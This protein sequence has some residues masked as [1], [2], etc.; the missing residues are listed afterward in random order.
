MGPGGS[1]S[2]LPLQGL[3]PMTNFKNHLP[4]L[5]G[6]GVLLL[7]QCQT[8]D[9][10]LANPGQPSYKPAAYHSA[11][12]TEYEAQKEVEAVRPDQDRIARHFDL[13]P[14]IDRPEVQKWIRHITG[15][16]KSSFE[17]HLQRGETL[18]PIIESVLLDKDLPTDLYYLALIE[19]GFRPEAR[20]HKKAVGVWQFI[21]G[22]GKRYGL[23]S[24]YYVD[25]RRD[26][27]RATL[28]AAGYLSDL[29][30]VFQSWFLAFS[31]YSTGEGRVLNAIMRHETRSYWKLIE[32][33]ALPAETRDYVPKLI[34][35]AW[36]AQHADRYGI[37]R[38][39]S[40]HW[41]ELHGVT[42]PAG[43]ALNKISE[44][45]GISNSD[46]GRYNPHLLR[47]VVPP[48]T[49]SYSLWLPRARISRKT[50]L[51]L[52]KIK[53]V[54]GSLK[55]AYQG[56]ENAY[57]IQAGDALHLIAKKFKVSVADIKRENQLSSNK[58]IAGRL[59]KIPGHQAL[60]PVKKKAVGKKRNIR[61]RA[62]RLL[63]Y[64]TYKVR[65]GDTLIK[66]AHKFGLSVNDLKRKNRL[67]SVA[68]FP[69]QILKLRV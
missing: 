40:L 47:G 49:S 25:E 59:L 57:R 23:R 31:A 66:I 26:P 22:T 55:K 58:L 65:R 61:K 69:G 15:P 28:A 56:P 50:E 46:I 5:F 37:R 6:S 43:V 14:W 34:A 67:T 18:R 7:T 32:K 33:K 13:E 41:P 62:S 36:V 4:K 8:T 44:I 20:S 27:V 12:Y 45:A 10:D 39:K 3:L 2:E 16:G 63:A 19:S 21:A 68:I 53:P 30:R 52:L 48:G 42:V 51:A 9:Q 24:S 35:S 11:A 64:K 29:Y 1:F 54:P 17:T 60:I 38:P